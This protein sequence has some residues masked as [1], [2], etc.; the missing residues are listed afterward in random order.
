MIY[1]KFTWAQKKKRKKTWAHGIDPPKPIL[2]TALSPFWIKTDGSEGKIAHNF[3]HTFALR[4][5]PHIFHGQGQCPGKS[6]HFSDSSPDRELYVN[7]VMIY[8]ISIF[9]DISIDISRYIYFSCQT[10]K[11][12]RTKAV[13]ESV[14]QPRCVAAISWAWLSGVESKAQPSNRI[15][16]WNHD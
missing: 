8:P 5:L 14:G 13:V 9:I 7:M 16:M 15:N 3:R 1:W 4:Y 6:S 11:C 12:K 10:W 2:A